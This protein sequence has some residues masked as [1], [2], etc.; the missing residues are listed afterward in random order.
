[1]KK[2]FYLLAL[3]FMGTL[4]TFPSCGDDDDIDKG[5]Q[6]EKPD[7]GDDTDDTKEEV[8]TATVSCPSVYDK[9]TYFKFSDGS[10]VTHDIEPFAGTYSGKMDISVAGKD[11]GSVEDLK[12]E[13]DRVDKDSVN[14]VVKNFKFGSYDMGDIAAGAKVSVDSTGW[15]L[16]VAQTTTAGNVALSS[17]STI[18]GK[19]IGIKMTMQPGAMPMQIIT[20]YAG[21]LETSAGIDETS[22][23]WDIAYHYFDVKT[24]G[25]SVTETTE[26]DLS[27][28]TAI[29]ADGYTAD[30]ETDSLLYDMT[31]MMDNK[32]GYAS[33]HI[34][35]V[36]GKS[37]YLD[38][39]NM[40]PVSGKSDKVYVIKTKAGEYVKMKVTD[41]T[42]D[43]GKKGYFTFD[44]VYPFK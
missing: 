44:Y 33:G 13:I 2:R 4:T 3:L 29:P 25:G 42:D 14:I 34:N 26:T 17:E 41:F 31:G 43:N 12:I 22:F 36:L 23:D 24:N 6:T 15:K 35:E 11:Q 37:A 21:E 18:K 30:I 38:L 1:M 10:A 16:T 40:P 5:G 27:K 19:T 28:L 39:T 9:W 7:D 8:K 20:T 32:I